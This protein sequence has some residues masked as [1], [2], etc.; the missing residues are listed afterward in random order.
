MLGNPELEPEKPVTKNEVEEYRK[1]IGEEI[2][3]LLRQA[4]STIKDT[5]NQGLR[6]MVDYFFE[7][8]Y[9]DGKGRPL[10]ARL[11]FETVADLMK[12][13]EPSLENS[14]TLDPKIINNLLVAIRLLDGASIILDDIY[15]H[16]ETRDDQESVWKKYNSPEKAGMAGEA[17]H[18]LANQVFRQAIDD[19]EKV[20]DGLIDRSQDAPE[21]F[22]SGHIQVYSQP[23][24]EVKVKRDIDIQKKMIGIWDK[25]WEDGYRG[26]RHDY[27][28]F[29]KDASP[30]FEDYEQRLYLLTGQFHERVMLL[31]AYAAGLD[32]EGEG[33]EILEAL[34]DYGKYYGTLVQ[35][36]NDLV[37]FL[38]KE[39]ANKGT[40]AGNKSFKFQDFIEGRQ[41]MPII[42]AHE[43]CS[44]E[45]WEYIHERIGQKNLTDEEKKKINKILVDR[46]IFKD[47]LK[48]IF[49]LSKMTMAELDKIPGQSRKKEMLQVWA[50]AGNNYI[51]KRFA[52]EG[53]PHDVKLTRE[54]LEKLFSQ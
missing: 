42:L 23:D 31:G 52:D 22:N 7:P 45:D 17:A 12:Q 34:G 15:D 2:S 14:S 36:R 40:V 54:D 33:K 29:G 51:K 44:P 30:S 1:Q 28:D 47:C 6:E 24:S 20:Y 21:V 38:P 35:L 39:E 18:E 19:Q 46:G 37:D 16:D 25:I 26:Q 9:E 48:R 50:M 53:I 3:P 13:A 5:D 4:V 41:T 32:D 49:E 10:L 43:K 8:R 27:D 11:S